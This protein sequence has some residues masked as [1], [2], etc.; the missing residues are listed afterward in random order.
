MAATL[1]PSTTGL[2]SHVTAEKATLYRA[3]LDTFAA[4]KRQFRLHLRPDEVLADA[5]WPQQ[6]PTPEEL[7]A[8]LTQLVDWGNLQAQPDTA[9]VASI[10]DFYRK[11]LLYRMTSG[12]EAV[13][14]GLGVF[15]STL[16]QRAEL[17]SVALED[18]RARLLA[19]GGLATES[20]LDAPKIH[21]ALRDLVHVFEGLS[22]NAEAFMAGL[23]RTMD[24][25]RADVAV[26]MGFKT[27]LIDYLQRFIGDLVTRS[28]QIGEG[29]RGLLPYEVDLLAVTAEREARDAAPGD[30]AAESEAI[31]DRL[32]AWGERWAGLKRW[33]LSDARGLSQSE[34]LRRSAL[35]AIPRLLQAVSVLNERRAGRSDR[36]A[37]FRRLAMWFLE[38]GDDRNAHRL[39]HS[40]FALSPARHLSLAVTGD[41]TAASTCWKDASPVEVFPLLREQ[42]ALPTRGALPKI[43]DR[44]VERALLAAR[45]KEEAAQAEAARRRLAMGTETRLSAIGAL[46]RH[47]FRLFLALLGDALA[48]QAHPDE[49]V[50]RTTADGTLL[51]RMQSLGAGTR[52]VIETELGRFAG[53][54][55]RVTIREV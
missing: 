43:R 20:P 51:V 42:G 39:W 12:G 2:F 46:D 15:V 47:A 4:A 48:S 26:V 44:T 8:A 10:E 18:I 27:R 35:S 34:L 30:A 7:Q 45:V 32:E 22:A 49:P 25:Q 16:R 29:L 55:Y 53:R 37:D 41:E 24:L 13:E 38:A 52:A 5:E 14:A 1:P 50:E 28:S 23:A 6:R 9:R 17:Q 3:I 11:R 19:L 21:L 31:S 54:D 36:A 40:A 33:F